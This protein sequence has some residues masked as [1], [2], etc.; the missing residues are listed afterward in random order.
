MRGDLQLLLIQALVVLIPGILVTAAV[1][2]PGSLSIPGRIALSFVGGYSVV[3]L[4]TWLLA[5]FSIL[6]RTTLTVGLGIASVAAAIVAW[7]RSSPRERFH[8][9]K[10]DFKADT[11]GNAV[12]LA[13]MGGVA[14]A[15]LGFSPLPSFL[16]FT[17]MRFWGDG[18]EIATSGDVPHQTLQ[19]GQSI[20][21]AASKMFTNCFTAAMH[22]VGGEHALINITG[23]IWL[24]SVFLVPVL[25]WL[26]RELGLTRVAPLLPLVLVANPFL[27]PGEFTK[28]L[29]PYRAESFGRAVAFS[30]LA[31]AIARIHENGNWGDFAVVG[32][33]F[34]IAAT[35]HLVPTVVAIGILVWFL[36]YQRVRGRLSFRLGI[37]TAAALALAGLVT[38]T[39]W[40]L[41]G[42][43]LAFTGVKQPAPVAGPEDR[44]DPTLLF[45]S[46]R[47]VPLEKIQAR[48]WYTP[49]DKIADRLV[50]D[51][52]EGSV[53]NGWLWLFIAVAIAVALLFL[54]PDRL[55][56]IA[57]ASIATGVNIIV[58]S[59]IFSR[60]YDSMAM[61]NFGHRRLFDY[62]HLAVW[63]IIL[64][65]VDLVLIQ[66]ARLQPRIAPAI[67][68]T[69]TLVLAVPLLSDLRELRE[70]PARAFPQIEVLDWVRDN[71]DCD[72]RILS[73]TRTSGAF[74]VLTGRAGVNEGMGPFF[75]PELLRQVNRFLIDTKAFYWDPENGRD[76]LEEQ[77]VDYV[78]LYRG[79]G[80]S[81]AIRQAKGFPHLMEQ[82]PFL[83][84]V[85]SGSA[86]NIY[87]VDGLSPDADVARPSD[88][89]GYVCQSGSIRV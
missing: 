40:F 88:H 79:V 29:I 69:L 57:L 8:D 82:T 35:T 56:P 12:G 9:L 45:S 85:Y 44:V 48:D 78:V 50:G 77:G 36:V 42:A 61:A 31:L 52:F 11:W 38:A 76:F 86:A 14:W 19:W 81:R 62:A 24:V 68:V 67:V 33:L 63:L 15:R 5:V 84:L 58:A 28:D 65:V 18:V 60:L 80:D 73:N 27:L 30:A 6:S 4:V 41:P 49:P 22:L 46:G 47:R 51:F 23:P 64:L 1:L 37:R 59:L 54:A 21:P 34:G 83:Q 20:E 43:S 89:P 72:A 87:R 39:I 71:T 16:S 2:R 3:S 26:G 74:Q 53:Q 13:V 7:R 10:Q 25:W 55:R 70:H 66:I 17:G 75:R 32:F